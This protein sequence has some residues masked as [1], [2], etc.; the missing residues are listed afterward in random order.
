MKQEKVLSGKDGMSEFMSKITLIN[1]PSQQF[2]FQSFKIENSFPRVYSL[3]LPKD[4]RKESG[5]CPLN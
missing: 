4:F 1:V 5:G 2:K 3:V